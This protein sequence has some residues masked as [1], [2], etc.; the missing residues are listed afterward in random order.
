MTDIIMQAYN[1]LDELKQDQRF[2]EM[3]L[4]NQRIGEE[5]ALEVS[6]FHEKKMI[7]DDIMEHGGSY[8]PDFKKVVKDYA[9]AKANLYSKPEVVRYFALEKA[10]QDDINDFLRMMSESISD[11]IKTPNKLGIIQKGGSC[12]VR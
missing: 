11:F 12:H 6:L 8:H 5:Y 1:V 10:F 2:I 9:E 3:K 7:Y 4:L